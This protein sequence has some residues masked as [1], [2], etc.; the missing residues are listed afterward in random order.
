MPYK[1]PIGLERDVFYMGFTAGPHP[2]GYTFMADP[3]APRHYK[4]PVKIR[5]YLERIKTSQA[6]EASFMP[7]CGRLTSFALLDRAGNVLNPA[8]TTDVARQ[9]A[10]LLVQRL[11]PGSVV[12]GFRAVTCM[13]I[14]AA[15]LIHLNAD[16][17]L[18]NSTGFDMSWFW[19]RPQEHLLDPEEILLGDGHVTDVVDTLALLKFMVPY[20][21]PAD[22]RS[23]VGTARLIRQLCRESRLVLDH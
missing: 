18:L 17:P 22:F 8:P 4:D 7:V 10:D 21:D 5:E 14:L 16:T 13:R 19:T 11:M 9:A 15:E 2:L 20:H 12:V 23:A 3:Q 1:L 6:A